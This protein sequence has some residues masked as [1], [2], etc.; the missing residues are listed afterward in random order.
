MYSEGPSFFVLFVCNER[1]LKLSLK[2]EA[3][4][5][6]VTVSWL[7]KAT[8]RLNMSG[9]DFLD[10]VLKS[11]DSLILNAVLQLC[12]S[13]IFSVY[14]V[15]VQLLPFWYCDSIVLFSLPRLEIFLF[16]SDLKFSK[17]FLGESHVF[18]GSFFCAFCWFSRV[19][20][21]CLLARGSPVRA[22]DHVRTSLESLKVEHVKTSLLSSSV[23]IFQQFWS[24]FSSFLSFSEFSSY[25]LRGTSSFVACR[26]L[27]F[28]Q[29]LLQGRH[30]FFCSKLQRVFLLRPI[31]SESL[32]FLHFYSIDDTLNLCQCTRALKLTLNMS[33]PAGSVWKQLLLRFDQLG[34]VF[35]RCYSLVS[36]IFHCPFPVPITS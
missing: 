7:V 13:L 31:F 17:R 23:A 34:W 6:T 27:V 8:E 21:L 10:L 2:M 35:Q 33:Q 26:V 5:T 29:F 25:C 15:H 18:G 4:P 32:S 20:I 16:F 12:F 22:G 36:Y 28:N 9:L 30:S 3:L 1:E 19:L 24:E 14:E 11:S